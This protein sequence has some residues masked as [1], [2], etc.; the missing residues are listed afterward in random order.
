MSQIRL[1]EIGA[2]PASDRPPRPSLLA[3]AGVPTLVAAGLLDHDAMIYSNVYAHLYD[4]DMRAASSACDRVLRGAGWNP[5][6]G[7][8]GWP[9]D[10]RGS[11]SSEPA[12]SP[13]EC[14]QSEV[15]RDGIE[16]LTFR[17]LE[18]LIAGM[19]R[20]LPIR[21]EPIPDVLSSARDAF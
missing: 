10:N 9:L 8:E 12:R 21:E 18:G 20:A 16:P 1:F 6:R 2:A 17:F 4:D 5:A 19:I 11:E 3:S 14:L 13:H 15:A 7:C